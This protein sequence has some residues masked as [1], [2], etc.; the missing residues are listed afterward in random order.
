MSSL[1]RKPAGN[2]LNGYI[3]KGFKPKPEEPEPN[4][5]QDAQKTQNQ[6]IHVFLSF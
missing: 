4:L 2:R 6:H 1:Y 5:P 3:I